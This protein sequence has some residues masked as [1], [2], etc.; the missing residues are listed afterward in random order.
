MK[1]S[2][3]IL[4]VN[5]ILE[6]LQKCTMLHSDILTN[7][8]SV[9]ALQSLG[10]NLQHFEEN[11]IELRRSLNERV[12]RIE[13]TFSKNFQLCTGDFVINEVQSPLINIPRPPF[14]RSTSFGR[15]LGNLSSLDFSLGMG[16]SET[17]KW[18]KS[19]QSVLFATDPFIHPQLYL[20]IIE[21]VVFQQFSRLFNEESYCG[22]LSL[23][24]LEDNIVENME[25]ILDLY[26]NVL[27]DLLNS[28]YSKSRTKSN[29]RS[30]EILVCISALCFIFDWAEFRYDTLKDYS[31]ALLSEDLQHLVLPDNREIEIARKI[32]TYILAHQGRRPLFHLGHQSETM[33]FALAFGRCHY[34]SIWKDLEKAGELKVDQR[35]E[36]ICKKKEKLSDLRSQ[37]LTKRSE[38]DSFTPLFRSGKRKIWPNEYY[39]VRNQ[40]RSL[41]SEIATT[42]SAPERIIQALPKD[43][44]LAYQWLFF[45]HMPHCIQFVSKFTI[46][47]KQMFVP[48][49]SGALDRY[50]DQP[51]PISIADHFRSN[52]FTQWSVSPFAANVGAFVSIP[53]KIGSTSVDYISDRYDGVYY[54]DSWTL[55]IQCPLF[56]PF[57]G[58]IAR[59]ETI[60]Y[61]TETLP[62]ES[63]DLQWALPMI[64]SLERGN[65]GLANLHLRPIWLQKPEY[66]TFATLRSFPHS[67]F[68]NLA[69]CLQRR[70]LPFERSEVQ[71]MIR[72]I[73]SEIGPFLP[74]GSLTW[75][76]D[77][78][79]VFPFLAR[80]LKLRWT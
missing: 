20:S 72:Q 12:A 16:L 31:P 45:L 56:N 41:E 54:P 35:W 22:L 29:L 49:D 34:S 79:D 2:Y 32:N 36:T 52:M 30:H 18:A 10:L 73:F 33:L 69:T 24:G 68:R 61:F 6:F 43:E 7:F 27:K 75:R 60:Q 78:V 64:P 53:H 50:A 58:K 63:Q 37:L 67:Q 46:L 77:S 42:S 17:V 65:I 26:R 70:S 59:S 4:Q 3:S 48:Q 9:H 28:K 1:L 19:K 71:I 38:C 21:N 55:T 80:L 15:T 40:I 14:G 23:D 57:S 74:N 25:E 76:G 13:R 11:C 51:F 5:T 47:C 8:R 66:L 62:N 44:S 39:P